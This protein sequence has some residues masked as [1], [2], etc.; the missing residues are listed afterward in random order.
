MLGTSAGAGAG[1]GIGSTKALEL[2]LMASLAKT[3]QRL[4][5]QQQGKDVGGESD[6][7]TDSEDEEITSA[8]RPQGSSSAG[9]SGTTK[10]QSQPPLQSTPP[11][12]TFQQAS[13]LPQ[14]QLLQ[15]MLPPQQQQQQQQQ[16]QLYQSMLAGGAPRPPT[17]Q[18]HPV[19]PGQS[20]LYLF[21]PTG[22][23]PDAP[24]LPPYLQMLQQQLQPPSQMMWRDPTQR[25]HPQLHDPTQPFRPPVD[26]LTQPQFPPRPLLAGDNASAAASLQ[27]WLG[28]DPR[29]LMGTAPF[30]AMPLEHEQHLQQQQLQ[31]LQLEQEQQQQQQQ[32][33]QQQEQQQ[34]QQ[35]QQQRRRQQPLQAGEPPPTAANKQLTQML[36]AAQASVRPRS[37]RNALDLAHAIKS[38]DEEAFK[39]LTGKAAAAAVSPKTVSKKRPLRAAG[40]RGRSA[41][42]ATGQAQQESDEDSEQEDPGDGNDDDDNK[43]KEA[44]KSNKG[45]GASRAPVK[46]EQA[47][48]GGAGEPARV[49][50]GHDEELLS[51]IVRKEQSYPLRFTC[52]FPG[53]NRRFAWNWTMETHARTH[54]GDAGRTYVCAACGKGFF[55]VGCLRS[56]ANIHVRKPGAFPCQEE[57]CTKAYS[58]SEGLSLHVRN[59][60]AAVKEFVCP[61]TGCD[62]AFVRQADLKLHVMRVHCIEKPF[63]CTVPACGKSFACLSELKRH[64]RFHKGNSF[65]EAALD[66]IESERARKQIKPSD[67]KPD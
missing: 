32:H 5:Q 43:R 51:K 4:E 25:F 33:R 31:L 26:N 13:S 36:A 57:S 66:A 28:V 14:A 1:A 2:L 56:H 34:Q 10:A 3:K 55:T 48:Q 24:P 40:E 17:S 30:A 46:Q 63:P 45:Q 60:H 6:S 59:H 49:A 61:E 52:T 18:A 27:Q 53:C 64:L 16:Q 62:K 37:G 12:Q 42:K 20:V 41:K 54:L 58:T 38:I 65:A 50:V 7:G 9:F 47:V 29:Q 35:Q 67:E 11:L 21:G 19:A 15:P 8:S 44:R 23:L 39:P 22:S